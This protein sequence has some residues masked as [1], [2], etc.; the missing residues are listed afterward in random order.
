MKFTNGTSTT[1]HVFLRTIIVVESGEDVRRCIFTGKAELFNNA[2]KA[3]IQEAMCAFLK[4]P[5]LITAAGSKH[6][7]L[8]HGCAHIAMPVGGI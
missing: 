6:N 4:G 7:G 8:S 3:F 1:L 5:K 2:P